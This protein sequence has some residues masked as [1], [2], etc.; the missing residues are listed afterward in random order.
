MKRMG[1]KV[2]KGVKNLPEPQED[3]E[4]SVGTRDE[5]ACLSAGVSS[6]LVQTI[7]VS[8][9]MTLTSTPVTIT[10]IKFVL[11][12]VTENKL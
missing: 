11:K 3:E 4:P 8:I 10:A 5:A 9:T 12:N 7:R 6:T 2:E 1:K